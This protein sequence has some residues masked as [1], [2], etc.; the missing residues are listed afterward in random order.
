MQTAPLFSL[1]YTSVRPNCIL[2]VYNMWMQRAKNP[3]AIEWVINTHKGYNPQATAV[4][5][6]LAAERPDH[7]K[8]VVNTGLPNC[9]TGWNN[10]AA[11]SRGMVI[12][13][14]A[15]DFIP[16]V[17]WDE[18]L[19]ALKPDNWWL[20]DHVVHV[21]DGYVHDIMVLS[22]LTRKRYERFGYVF[23]PKYVSMFCLDPETPVWMGDLTF[24]PAGSVQV[25][26]SV[27]GTERRF[28]KTGD[29]KQKRSFLAAT[30]VTK[31]HARTADRV[32]LTLRSGRTLVCTPDHLWAY[33]ADGRLAGS[34]AKVPALA[35]KNGPIKIE[36]GF[37]YGEPRRHRKLLHVVD[38]TPRLDL[39]VE[40]A[41][42]L[43][44]LAGMMDGEGCF[45]VISQSLSVNPAICA[46]IRRILLKHGF[47]FSENDYVDKR[48]TRKT[49]RE[50]RQINFTLTG[51]RDA[52][53]R[54]INHVQPLKRASDAA[55]KRILSARFT[56]PD[57]IESI[58]PLGEGPVVCLSTLTGNFIAG[59]YLSHNCDTEFTEV[60]RREGVVIEAK[61]LLFEHMHPDCA[62]RPRDH[63]DVLH[64]SKANWNTGEMIFNFR[65][66]A[67]FPVDD[68]P[69]AVAEGAAPAPTGPASAPG[70]IKFAVYMQ[71]IKDDF[72]LYEVCRRMMDEGCLDFFW[73]VPDTYW[74]GEAV[75][76]DEHATLG[77]ILG[78]LRSEGARVNMRV[79]K[80]A[81]YRIG[82]ESRITVE[83][84]LRNDSLAWV[85]ESGFP[86][87]LIVDG[88]EL[89]KPGTLDIVRPFVI[90]G[91]AA[92]SVGMTPVMGTPGYP[93]D[94]AGDVA[95]V[96]IGPSCTFRVCRSPSVQQTIIH[97]PQ[98]IHFTSTRKTAEENI[99]K[100]RRSGHY[101]DPEYA[102]ED[103]IANKL[104]KAQPGLQ[105]AHMYT[106]RSIWPVLRNWRPEELAIIPASLHPFLGTPKA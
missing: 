45:P 33:K 101:D 15:D 19:L 104:P 2:P 6:A 40:S 34:T 92:I 97:L 65:K 66:A 76:V 81:N 17:G 18:S 90:E 46:E 20:D 11:H 63:N 21:E 58:T 56:E 8:S 64:A 82:S 94:G 91:H 106:K 83:T 85:R 7:V 24:R 59:G 14:V 93:V 1:V 69:R 67:G 3:T 96:Y 16:P 37:V 22:M 54:F 36:N 88:D 27:I 4:A 70:D 77:P 105:D 99:A 73:A 44:W 53:V 23:Y 95:V 49:G 10:A 41:R 102:F 35:L 30:R 9:V 26:D 52:Y 50:H 42:E 71:V 39:T 55:L 100:H 74:S 87:V 5:E 31:T 47:E 86:H 13:A 29:G 75:S 68:G 57:E 78:R 43:G 98:V 51:G 28:G 38:P 48:Y 25:G 12:I 61:H 32:R 72:C 84:R 89:W 60:A 80:V 62:K 79:F 103:W